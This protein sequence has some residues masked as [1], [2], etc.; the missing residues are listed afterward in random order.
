M[1]NADMKM[2]QKKGFG[3]TTKQDKPMEFFSLLC[4]VFFIY[5]KGKHQK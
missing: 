5:K 1:T 3:D 2:N 4:F